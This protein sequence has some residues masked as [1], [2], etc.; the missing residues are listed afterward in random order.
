MSTKCPFC[1]IKYKKTSLYSSEHYV[2]AFGYNLRICFQR[3]MHL[4]NGESRGGSNSTSLSDSG[5]LLEGG[6]I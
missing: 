5:V 2:E 4:R 1:N 6:G 3:G